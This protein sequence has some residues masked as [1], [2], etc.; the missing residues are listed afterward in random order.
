MLIETRC[1]S[2]PHLL[3]QG[4]LNDTVRQ[5]NLFKK[6]AEL[7]GSRLKGSNLIHQNGETCF[8][9]NRQNE[10]KEFFSQEPISYIVL[11]LALL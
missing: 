9:R 7:L 5:F 10:F 6:Q 2:E 1:S 3:T 8:F 11:M 4:D